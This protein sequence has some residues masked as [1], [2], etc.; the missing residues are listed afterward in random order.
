[1]CIRVQGFGFDLRNK[2]YNIFVTSEPDKLLL[3]KYIVRFFHVNNY[4]Y[5]YSDRV[6]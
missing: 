6:P 4:L 5:R 3:S 1:M 2:R